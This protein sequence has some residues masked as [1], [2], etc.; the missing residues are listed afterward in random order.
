[1]PPS[2]ESSAWATLT[3][4]PAL[5]IPALTKALEIFGSARGII[6]TSD[7][8]RERA[9]LPAAAREFRSTAAAASTPAESEGLERPGHHVVPFPDPRYPALLRATNRHTMPLDVA[10]N[11]DP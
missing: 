11:A 7:A 4:A 1:M 10:R 6:D 5:G 9:G 3:R 2:E 8:S